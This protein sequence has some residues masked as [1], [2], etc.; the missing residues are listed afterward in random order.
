MRVEVSDQG[1]ETDSRR[2]EVC[3]QDWEKQ[4]KTRI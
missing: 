2:Q 1:N 3:Y 4:N